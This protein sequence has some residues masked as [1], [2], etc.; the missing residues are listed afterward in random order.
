MLP[1]FGR[2]RAVVLLNLHRHIGDLMEHRSERSGKTRR[3]HGQA[4]LGE[5]VRASWGRFRKRTIEHVS[6]SQNSR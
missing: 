4:S 5:A 1:V 6:I 3:Q 2:Y